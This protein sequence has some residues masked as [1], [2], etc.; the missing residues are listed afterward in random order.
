MGGLIDYRWVYFGINF[1]EESRALYNSLFTCFYI[2]IKIDLKKLK[3]F[4]NIM[5]ADVIIDGLRSEL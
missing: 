3:L 1:D 5:A 4:E 2:W